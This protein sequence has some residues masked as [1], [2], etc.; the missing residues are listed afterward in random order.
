MYKNELI[1]PFIRSVDGNQKNELTKPLEYLEKNT[2]EVQ[3]NAIDLPIAKF[4]MEKRTRQK[5]VILDC[6]KKILKEKKGAKKEKPYFFVDDDVQECVSK[7]LKNVKQ[8]FADVT[9]IACEI[10]K[11]VQNEKN[12]GGFN[13]VQD[14]IPSREI[15]S[16]LN[17]Q[18][19]LLKRSIRIFQTARGECKEF[20]YHVKVFVS[21]RNGRVETY[22]KEVSGDKIKKIEW[23]VKATNSLVTIPSDKSEKQAFENM[24]QMCIEDDEAETEIIYPHAGWW[25]VAGRGW[26]FIDGHGI[27]G[28]NENSIYVLGE[29]LQFNTAILPEQAFK[30]MLMM[31][32]ITKNSAAQ[33]L[34]VFTHS[35]FLS[36]IFQ[37]VGYPIKFV[38]G[39]LGVT[40]SRKT[41]MVLAISKLYDNERQIAD[42]EFATATRCGIEKTLSCHKD[43]T[44]IIDDFKPGI[45]KA[46]Q[47][48]LDRKLDELVRMY[49]D[50]VPKKRMTEFLEGGEKLFFPVQGAAVITLEH[51]TGVL[52]TMTRMFIVELG[53]DDVQ[54]EVLAVYQQNKLIMS[55]HLRYF[56]AWVTENFVNVCDKIRKRVPE[57]R[58]D[59]KFSYGRFAETY[60][61]LMSTAEIIMDYARN[62]SFYTFEEAEKFLNNVKYAIVCTI[63]DME[64]RLKLMDKGEEIVRILMLAI[65]KGQIVLPKLTAETCK[66]NCEFYENDDFIFVKADVLN[67]IIK[68][69]AKA[70][71]CDPIVHSKSELFMVL[72]RKEILDIHQGQMG[73][74]RARK[75]PIQYGNTARYLYMR[76]E[77]INKILEEDV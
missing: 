11:V 67:R 69:Y 14:L 30:Q 74:E 41:S 19:Q 31:Q 62:N 65:D 75:L 71:S 16:S 59:Y 25:K 63:L 23:V 26:R 52:S 5:E 1:K 55:T 58:R 72:E 46:Q 76:K 68:D 22:S 35:S 45:S 39:I 4:D 20:I 6:G 36:T 15:S 18:L 10:S 66:K 50:R 21:L 40:N 53:K 7:M 49:G 43:G 56:L 61:L 12:Q 44:I 47:L 27:V 9:T 37:E 29:K 48:E 24:V 2:F 32:N 33:L 17:F 13:Y 70:Y 28:T 77:K 42:A 73:R 3:N 57:L 38:F 34:I 60:A 54:N 8:N 64:N 51:V